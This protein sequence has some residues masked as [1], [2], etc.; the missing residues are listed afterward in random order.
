MLSEVATRFP[1]YIACVVFAVDN[2]DN[3]FNIVAYIFNSACIFACITKKQM[4]IIV[5]R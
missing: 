5:V 3:E 2:V 4:M 1:N